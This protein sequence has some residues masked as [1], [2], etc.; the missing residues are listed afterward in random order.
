M[1]LDIRDS[2]KEFIDANGYKKAAIA[3]AAGL[4][5]AQLSD[6]FGK[7]RKLDANEF[8]LI[9]DFMRATPCEI[10]NSKQETA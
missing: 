4:S 2:L 9:C 1:G 6:I 7:R 3:A 8:L 10:R 5:N